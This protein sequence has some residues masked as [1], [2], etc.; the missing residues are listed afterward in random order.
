MQ[1]FKLNGSWA[2]L[3]ALFAGVPT[4][5]IVMVNITR[6]SDM[7]RQVTYYGVIWVITWAV[8][9]GVIRFVE[10]RAP[11]T[12]SERIPEAWLQRQR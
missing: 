4:P 9:A 3:P 5:I 2:T 6:Q 10:R 12:R 11:H 1:F 7:S 8:L